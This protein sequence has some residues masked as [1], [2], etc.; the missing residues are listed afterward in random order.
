MEM[1]G[2][3]GDGGDRWID[4]QTLLGVNHADRDEEQSAQRTDMSF[5][6][7]NILSRAC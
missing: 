6:D 1:V 3:D 2:I 5:G 7:G 4:N